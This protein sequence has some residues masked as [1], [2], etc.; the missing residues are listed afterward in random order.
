MVFPS[1]D[2]SDVA[3]SMLNDPG[4]GEA[5]LACWERMMRK[6]GARPANAGVYGVV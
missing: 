5:A 2:T 6:C 3:L 4:K 1:A